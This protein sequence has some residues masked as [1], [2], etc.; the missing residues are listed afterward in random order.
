[1]IIYRHYFLSIFDPLF[2]AIVASGLANSIVF[3]L[4]YHQEIKAH[5]FYSFVFTE[6]AFILGFFLFKP[7]KP[8]TYYLS[9]PAPTPK[10]Q[11]FNENFVTVL[12]YWSSIIHMS[13]QLITYLVVGL[14]ILMESRLTAYAGGSGF[15]LVGRFVDVSSGIGV[16][17]VFYRIFYRTN[18]RADKIY[19]ILYLSGNKT[20]LLLLVYYLFLLNIYMLKIKGEGVKVQFARSKKLQKILL[21]I[22]IPL[23]F[24]VIAIQ[25]LTST[26]DVSV[27]DAMLVL[28]KRVVS[29]GDIY[30]LTLPNDVIAQLNDGHSSFLQLFKDPLGV[31]RIVPWSQLPM[32]SGFAVTYYHYGETATGPNP[33][34]NYFAILYY[35]I[36][37]QLIYCFIVGMVI[38]FLRNKLFAM[39]PRQI[40]FGLVY[41]IV[42][43]NIVYAFQDMPTLIIHIFSILLIFP[44]ICL[45]AILSLKLL[46]KYNIQMC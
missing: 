8:A 33:R 13:A 1:M 4:F 30:Y 19:N 15:G 28:L 16:F 18:V 20:N 6:I 40:F 39:L 12:F 41:A 31:L 37:G 22:S 9:L 46:G 26:G 42:S 36:P 24:V 43:I 5:Y 10:N 7:I 32:D 45:L 3:Y 29:F 23:I 14:P 2:F 35:D 17:L 21:F 11:V 25:L 34:Y 27:S 38:S 44:I